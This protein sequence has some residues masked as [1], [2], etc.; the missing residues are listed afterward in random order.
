MSMSNPKDDMKSYK[1]MMG[2]YLGADPGSSSGAIAWIDIENNTIINKGFFEFSKHTLREW[3]DMLCELNITSKTS[4]VLENVH[5]MPKMSTVAVSTFMKNVGHIEMAL[6]AAHI[7]FEKVT[8]QKWMKFYGMKK[9]K[10]ETKTEWKKRL[11]EKLQ[12]LM[13]DLKVTN[14]NADAYLIAYYNW[15]TKTQ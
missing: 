14:N 5:G 1:N 15:K 7:P 6:T 9:D 8:P 4:L 2:R 13:P 11:R 12:Q 10:N 3:Y